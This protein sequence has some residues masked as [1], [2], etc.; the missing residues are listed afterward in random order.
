MAEFSFCI[1]DPKLKCL[2][3]HHFDSKAVFA[4]TDHEMDPVKRFQSN[5]R[6]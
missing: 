1:I 6:F 5:E 2:T 3:G 4:T